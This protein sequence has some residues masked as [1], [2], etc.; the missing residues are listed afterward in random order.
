VG[1]ALGDNGYGL[2][3]ASIA[4]HDEQYSQQGHLKKDTL[5]ERLQRY[6]PGGL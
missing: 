4:S 3:L 5:R 1:L 6:S 2:L